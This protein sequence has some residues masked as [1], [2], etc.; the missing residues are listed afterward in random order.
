VS[1]HECGRTS[2]GALKGDYN[3][4]CNRLARPCGRPHII[5]VA[6]YHMNLGYISRKGGRSASANSAYIGCKTLEEDRTGLV[7]DYSKKK[8]LLYQ[9]ILAPEGC[10]EW[11]YD[12][13]ILWNNV[14]AFE[15]LIAQKR[16]RGHIDP[17]KDAKSLEAKE[18]FLNSC[19]TAFTANFALPLEI[20][21][22]D[23][24]IDL[25]KRIVKACYVKKGLIADLAIHLDEGNPHLHIL[26]TTRPWEEDGFSET[27]FV[28][29]RE[30]LIEIRHLAAKVSN[31]FA[32]E[33]G[34][35][36][37]LDARSYEDRGLNIIP[38]RHLGPK[39]YHKH[40]EESRI[41]HENNE[42]QHENLLILFNRPEEI[43]KLVAG[44][45]VVF[46]QSDIAR[47]VFKRVGGDMLLY[48]LLKTR[49][50][51][52][53]IAPKM[54]ATANDPL[55]LRGEDLEAEYN[56]TLIVYAQ[57]MLHHESVVS[58]GK[59]LKDQAVF[60]TQQA[61][62]LEKNARASV[63]HL[64]VMEGKEI[65]SPLKDKAI[66]T[67]EKQNG[68]AFSEEQKEAIDYL[69]APQALRVFKGNAGTGKTTVLRPVVEAYKEAGY[70]PI[71]T[72]FQGKVSELLSHDLNIA[73]YTL[74]QLE[75][76]WR[77]YDKL[78]ACL[79]TLKGV[80]R[81][82]AKKELARLAPYQLN[83]RHVII[84]DEGNMVGGH[85][86][87][88]LLSRVQK[89]GAHLRI[90]QDNNQIKALQGADI[91]RLVEEETGHFELT[92]VHRQ[93]E[94]WMCEASGHLNKH[95]LITG[96]KPYE[97][98]GCLT[99]KDSKESTL[100]ALAEAYVNNLTTH[101]D[102][103][104]VALAFRNADVEDLNGAIRHQLK[105][106]GSLGESLTLKDKEFAVGDRIV[107]T[108]NDHTGRFIKTLGIKGAYAAR[109]SGPG[110]LASR[111]RGNKGVKN[112]TFGKIESLDENKSFLNVRLLKD[113]RLV[114]VNLKTYKSIDYGYAMTVNKAESQTFDWVYG[115]FDPLMSANK[116][117]IWM[118]R[119]R[120]GFSGFIL[121]AHASSAEEMAARAGRS[122][123][124]PLVSDFGM[125]GHPG[126]DLLKRYLKAAYE[127][128]NLWG[129][130]SRESSDS[131]N[132]GLS[133][134]ESSTQGLST[135][136]SLT[137]VSSTLE[138][139][140]QVLPVEHGEWADFQAAQYERNQIAGEIIENWES[141]RSFANQVGLKRMTLEIQAG[142]RQRALSDV[143]VEA[144]GRVETYRAVAVKARRLWEDIS[145]SPEGHIK[146]AP[147]M[148]EYEALV[149]T[150]NHLAYEI[151]SFPELHRPF[152]KTIQQKGHEN[153]KSDKDN[154]DNSNK[155]KDKVT[156][157]TYGGEIYDKI[158]PGLK[159]AQK[160]SLTYIKSQQ[161]KAFSKNLTSLERGAFEEL[162]TFKKQV[163]ECGRLAASLK[164]NSPLLKNGSLKDALEESSRTRDFLAF[165][166]V[167]FFEKY[168]SLLERAEISQDQLLK[169]G[170]FGEVR[171]LALKHTLAKT[172][173][174]RLE[175]AD[176]LH[177]MVI[178][179]DK[180]DKPLYGTLKG[181]GVELSRLRFEQGCLENMK[182]EGSLPF[183][184]VSELSSAFVMLKNYRKP[185]QEANDELFSSVRNQNKAVVHLMKSALGGAIEGS[186]DVLP[187]ES[188]AKQHRNNP[189]KSHSFISKDQVEQALIQNITSFA[190]D[191]FSSIGEPFH[192]SSSSATERRYGK[193]GHIAVNLRTGAW[194][195]H[196]TSLGGGPLQMLTELKGFSFDEAIEYGASRAGLSGAGLSGTE[197]SQI[198][199]KTLPLSHLAG[200]E[201][202]DRE[203][204]KEAKIKIQKAQALWKKGISIKG[205]VAERYLKEH[206]KVEGELPH[207][208]RYLPQFKDHASGKLF[209]GKLL[210][211]ELF[212][213]LMVAARSPKGEV[214]AVQITY[215][216]SETA[217]KA[218]LH[219]TKRS[220]GVLKG[221]F[222][223]LHEGK[224]SDPIFVAEGVETALSLKEAGVQGTIIASLG[225]SN[226]KRLEPKDLNTPIVI[227]ADHD[228]PDSAAFKS[229]DK[230]LH[231]LRE[232]GYQVHVVKP[233][234][235]EE[236]FNDVLKQ[237]GP[238]G[239]R[240][241][242]K[243]NLPQELIEGLQN[244]PTSSPSKE[245]PE[246]SQ[247]EQIHEIK[248]RS[249][250]GITQDCEHELYNFL[251]K[252]NRS[253]TSELKERV[254][255][256]SEKAANFIFHAHTLKGT[257]PSQEET[258]LFLLRAKYEFDRIP[259]IRL[260]IMKDWQRED[261]F[262]VKKDGFLAHMFA[263]RK[264]SIEGRLFLKAKQKGL[265]PP[266]DISD[267]AEKELKNNRNQ[268]K[269]LAQ[270]L[271]EKYSLPESISIHC[272]KDIVRYKEVH[273]EKPS[274]DQIASMIRIS[275]ELEKKNDTSPSKEMGS[276]E[277]E[278]LHRKEGDLLLRYMASH[279]KFPT[280][281][282]LSHIQTQAKTSLDAISPHIAQ[283]LS[284][285]NQ[286]EFSL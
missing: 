88:D 283:D 30:Q 15:D 187:V 266:P 183:K 243:R 18:K 186:K 241:I 279:D 55:G 210:P 189:E 140:T 166:I 223:T 262:D 174:R 103:F 23:D 62:D 285:L 61:L 268:T 165:K 119:H 139:T 150:R 228:A 235:L 96:I 272:A 45:K 247:K 5:R 211:R 278:F 234:T 176:Q 22:H 182:R 256:Q 238:Q 214:T 114:Q 242:L 81:Y 149:E 105:Q 121:N 216:D 276:H 67:A 97:E 137:Q 160:H 41:A 212:P 24:L 270:K 116:I 106:R 36:Y 29:D 60:T 125:E 138:S 111:G 206:R 38:G 92:E 181:M 136:V 246:K 239:I 151:I 217:S 34:Y 52:M 104:H 253:I 112:G 42:I 178:E 65:A 200:K 59:N 147:L 46:T 203:A 134:Q 167:K 232:K 155:D 50:E 190:D 259:E 201:N 154:N 221:S 144:L 128:G 260:E 115:L 159:A 37:V 71:G 63:Q 153:D 209:P 230:S 185:P 66:I 204:E 33:K 196:K 80:A 193:N 162:I 69:L 49:L 265:T 252:G 53:E 249:F 280:S 109:H 102:Q 192:K 231:A 219:V 110:D 245:S 152:F 172:V 94:K 257:N 233:D 93:K 51:G 20:E 95:D 85:H 126:A 205:T 273:G 286:R 72:A 21:N 54:L 164:N 188:Y 13:E 198:E 19:V 173:E 79:P 44:R 26:S 58:V 1:T 267:L 86:W 108:A 169:H 99:F 163:L 224:A 129:T 74:D 28:I 184:T 135:H 263:E 130:I 10:P 264:A 43:V 240:D 133:T 158:P 83:D 179:G 132:R 64:C 275:Q 220:F 25:S 2:K 146:T 14:E 277:I 16:F 78:K 123:Y 207:E 89:A 215:L 17:E 131:L 248:G 101:P 269:A 27:R 127:A 76:Y 236:D 222:V 180:V 170:V 141:C 197:L 47:E 8:G 195:D 157:I 77:P 237:G 254:I 251:K 161:Q 12:S 107:F 120:L 75:E 57:H 145:H 274:V 7:F 177:R 9:S 226:I 48:S 191:I 199:L 68:F 194:F 271:S 56:H 258:R 4:H 31:E 70:I 84:L 225:L 32:Q 213:C 40:K 90:V 124:R 208:L 3:F 255:L 35:N 142:L 284:K 117:L 229:L 100:Y 82:A 122:E 156:Y 118:S 218:E 39:A 171:Q 175:I 281:H 98:R 11:V 250:T 282:E 261:N 113:D 227:C 143:E 148:R 202:R 6:A 87:Q 168:S 244:E 91:S 73:A